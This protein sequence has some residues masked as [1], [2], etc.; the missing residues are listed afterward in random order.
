MSKLIGT[1]EIS[2]QQNNDFAAL[3]GD[4]NPLH[5]DPIYSRRLQFGRPVIHGIHHLLRA[6]DKVFS[7][8]RLTE[9]VQ[10]G[11]IKAMFPNPVS[12]GQLIEYES[13]FYKKE[14]TLDISA[15]SGNKTILSLK[16]SLVDKVTENIGFQVNNSSPPKETPILQDFPPH[17][18]EGDCELFL[19][20]VIAQKLFPTLSAALIPS[21][22]AT[23]LACTRVV[24]MKCPGMNSIFSRITLD[25]LANKKSNSN[26]RLH[27]YENYKD[28]RVKIMKIGVKQGSMKGELDTFFRPTPVPQ[29]SY[30]EICSKVRPDAFIGHRAIVIGGSRGAGE[31]T[32]KILAAGG[33]SIIVTYNKGEAEAQAIENEINAASSLG[34]CQIAQFD[35]CNKITQQALFFAEKQLPT[36][37]YFFASPYIQAN[38]SKTWDLNLFNNFCRF[39]LQAFSDVVSLFVNER[40]NEESLHFFYP[41]TI[42]IEKPEKGFSEYAVAKSAG[43][44]LCRQLAVQYTNSHYATPRLE[45]MVTDQTSSII[46]IKSDSTF[47]VMYR[48]LKK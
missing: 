41:S 5:V 8:Y 40:S 39:Y 31:A 4:F 30:K 7:Q 19:N 34:T 25:F 35:V 29:E 13:F 32:A 17:V 10:I 36:H 43:E 42:Y 14:N 21:Q 3:S 9:P 12:V 24:G 46:P 23:F 18:Y 20:K 37:I 45:R 22:L 27:Y 33:A 11:S 26:G 2:V 6:C 15:S 16:M 47:E 28:A 38:Q 44:A 48:A 1:F